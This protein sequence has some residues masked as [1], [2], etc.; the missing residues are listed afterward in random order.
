[1]LKLWGRVL[2]RLKEDKA[3]KL[4]W[5]LVPQE[6]FT[7]SGSSAQELPRIIDELIV[8]YAGVDLILLLW[9]SLEGVNGLLKTTHQHNALELMAS[10]SPHGRAD[11]V[12]FSLATADLSS[13]EEKVIASLQNKL[14]K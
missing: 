3:L 14:G 12:Q 1:M 6:D 2:A 9:Q 7:K 5:S 13:A 10:F 11:L 8:T 4:V